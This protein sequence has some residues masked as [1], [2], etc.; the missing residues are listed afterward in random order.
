MSAK[1]ILREVARK[2]NLQPIDILGT[3]RF[4]HFCAARREV[5]RTLRKLGYTN[6]QIGVALRRDSSTVQHY[7]SEKSQT[8]KRERMR[9]LREQGGSV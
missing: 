9:R 8:L 1:Q 4:S 2:H 5:A 7:C 6:G 3:D